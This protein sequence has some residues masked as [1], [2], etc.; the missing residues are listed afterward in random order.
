[1]PS[2]IHHNLH[3]I[4][5]Q[6]FELDTYF[7]KASVSDFWG[8]SSLYSFSPSE[9]TIIAINALE[10]HNYPL[11]KE[12]IV[13][14]ALF[15]NP[16]KDK[17]L[18]SLILQEFN[19]SCFRYKEQIETYLHMAG[20]IFQ[21]LLNREEGL[22]SYDY[23]D[24]KKNNKN[25]LTMIR[26]QSSELQYVDKNLLAQSYCRECF[27][28][29]G[30]PIYKHIELAQNLLFG[31]LFSYSTRF[32]IEPISSEWLGKM[33]ETGP[34]PKGLL[35]HFLSF[36]N[37]ATGIQIKSG[38]TYFS[39]YINDC[40]KVFGQDQHDALHYQEYREQKE[41]MPATKF[42]IGDSFSF[43]TTHY[44]LE[45]ERFLFTLLAERFLDPEENILFNSPYPVFDLNTWDSDRGQAF[46]GDENSY[47]AEG[48][49]F[50]ALLFYYAS[51]NPD[52]PM[53]E[54]I[55]QWKKEPKAF[56]YSLV[57]HSL[58]HKSV[59]EII[60][61][62]LEN[63]HLNIASLFN[64][65]WTSPE[66]L[67]LLVQHATSTDLL[68][69]DG[70]SYETSDVIY[71]INRE[72]SSFMEASSPESEYQRKS[73]P[74]N[75]FIEKLYQSGCDEKNNQMNDNLCFRALLNFS[76]LKYNIFK[77]L[78]NLPHSTLDYIWN[79]LN[80]EN[81]GD[82]LIQLLHAKSLDI[83]LQPTTPSS[84]K[85]KIERF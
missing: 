49:L 48:I 23:S 9:K 28:P 20:P 1:M 85:P 11:F 56:M 47:N 72:F 40:L 67:T 5:A 70:K 6:H 63:G 71:F 22:I 60:T 16:I 61:N 83:K 73:L 32:Q 54:N 29:D 82:I 12:A 84:H 10:K 39:N 51:K 58:S 53:L 65:S 78:E 68:G 69:S 25:V 76:Y 80:S 4:T 18:P 66:F 52:T 2:I 37:S 7:A 43:Q 42:S 38:L 27:E 44:T 41:K 17:T 26:N 75:Q 33:Q 31:Y 46:F 59:L 14:G 77:H 21:D 45:E 19:P 30:K 8:E 81:K 64:Q 62:T 36:I 79:H 34:L 3:K 15:E 13:Q 55:S 50:K 24:F 57:C 35:H 74:L